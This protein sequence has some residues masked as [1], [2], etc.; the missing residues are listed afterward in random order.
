ML[1]T[2]FILVA[3]SILDTLNVTV[4]LSVTSISLAAMATLIKVFAPNKKI[5]D[6]SLRSSPYIVGIES[7]IKSKE[8]KFNGL[9]EIVTLQHIEVEKLKV[10]TKNSSKGLEELKQ[11][12]RELVQRLDYILKQFMEYMES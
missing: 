1:F 6:E 10:E 12:N 3:S 2:T 9:K 4:V 5:N 8:E 11:D 7:D